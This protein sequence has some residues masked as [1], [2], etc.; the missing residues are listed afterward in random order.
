MSICFSHNRYSRLFHFQ[1]FVSLF[2]CF[3]LLLSPFALISHN[4]LPNDVPDWFAASG[5]DFRISKSRAFTLCATAADA[6]AA[7]THKQ[8]PV[9]WLV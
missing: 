2:F 5:F 9:D 8:F 7:A 1:P 3:L 4:F 6:A